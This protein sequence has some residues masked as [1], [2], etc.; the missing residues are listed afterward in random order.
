MFNVLLSQ[1][2]AGEDV[3]RR[4][5]EKGGDNHLLLLIKIV[6]FAIVNN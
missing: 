6:I 5:N 2:V 4:V 3:L 1:G